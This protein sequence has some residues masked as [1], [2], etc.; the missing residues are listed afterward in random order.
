MKMCIEGK[1]TEVETQH[2][3]TTLFSANVQPSSRS[4]VTLHAVHSPSSIFGCCTQLICTIWP[5]IRY[6][7]LWMLFKEF[8]RKDIWP[9]AAAMLTFITHAISCSAMQRIDDDRSAS[10]RWQ[11][12]ITRTTTTTAFA[13]AIPEVALALVIDTTAISVV[14]WLCSATV[15]V[16]LILLPANGSCCSQTAACLIYTLLLWV[17]I[18]F[19]FH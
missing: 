15:A 2:N 14:C 8:T 6:L 7:I 12:I 11:L 1:S 3:Q 13:A 17:F 4:H 18:A 5:G 19:I 9:T 16:M 10:D